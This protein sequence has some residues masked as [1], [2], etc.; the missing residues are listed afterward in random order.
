MLTEVATEELS[1][2]TAAKALLPI[3]RRLMSDNPWPAFVFII[4]KGAEELS[5]DF[6][7][8]FKSALVKE[9]W[10]LERKSALELIHQAIID[11]TLQFTEQAVERILTLTNCHPYLTQLLCWH[12]WERAYSAKPTTAPLIDMLDIEEAYASALKSG[13]PAL[14][15]WWEGLSSAEKV[16]AAALAGMATLNV[17]VPSERMTQVLA[18]HAVPLRKHLVD[19]A[20][21]ALVKRRV[22]EV[23]EEEEYRAS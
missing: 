2:T 4:G 12:I 21:R 20:S 11:G 13:E 22:L 6:S 16:Y 3:L 23:T 19:S 5:K 7:A 17:T 8:I 15:W 14:L 9:L 18:A 10:T 1:A